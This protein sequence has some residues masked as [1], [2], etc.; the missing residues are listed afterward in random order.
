MK[1]L[2][3]DRTLL[4]I[5]GIAFCVLLDPILSRGATTLSTLIAPWVESLRMGVIVLIGTAFWWGV[6]SLGGFRIR[7]LWSRTTLRF[8]PVWICG[9]VAAVVYSLITDN[10]RT[11]QQFHF[12]NIAMS[13][14]LCVLSAPVFVGLL[15]WAMRDSAIPENLV[16]RSER[17]TGVPVEPTCETR[18]AG[19]LP[20]TGETPFE[21]AESLM[22]WL[23]KEAPIDHPDQDCFNAAPIARRI[24]RLLVNTPLRTIG[25]V[26]NYGVGKSSVLNLVKHYLDNTDLLEQGASEHAAATQV[27]AQAQLVG[28]AITSW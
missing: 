25:L 13:D 27:N 11:P 21:S 23:Q 12:E 20:V 28:M 15:N 8:P 4:V 2:L 1:K 7:D 22:R 17:S 10:L 5:Y 14:M 16:A 18:R 26:G 24:A 3:L 19:A 6:A 9:V